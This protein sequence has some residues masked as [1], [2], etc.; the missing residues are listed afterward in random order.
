MNYSLHVQYLVQPAYL[1]LV[2]VAVAAGDFVLVAAA[3]FVGETVGA[4]VFV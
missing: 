4:F 2:R 3:D 1:V